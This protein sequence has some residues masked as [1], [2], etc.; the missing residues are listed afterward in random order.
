[1]TVIAIQSNSHRRAR[2]WKMKSQHSHRLKVKTFQLISKTYLN[3][4]YLY[5]HFKMKLTF[6]Y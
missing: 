4:F 1:M 5:I 3:L 6:N 2:E